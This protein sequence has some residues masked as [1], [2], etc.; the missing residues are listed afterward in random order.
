M[1]LKWLA[2]GDGIAA[3]DKA[4]DMVAVITAVE[5]GGYEVEYVTGSVEYPDHQPGG[6]FIDIRAAKL[7]VDEQLATWTAEEMAAHGVEEGRPHDT[8]AGNDGAD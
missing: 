6:E 1:K 3:H 2:D 4:L 8:V 5:G 7:A